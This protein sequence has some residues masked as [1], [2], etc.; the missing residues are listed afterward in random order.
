MLEII[1]KKHIADIAEIE[2]LCFSSPW[3]EK[4]LELLCRENNF[5]IAVT[6][7]EKAVAYGGM[8]C[9][10][11]E[12]EILNI[13]VHPDYRRRGYGRAVVRAL[14]AEAEKRGI[15]KIFLEVRASNLPAIALYSSEGFEEV[16]IR[17][18]FYSFP[19][20]DGIQMIY[21]KDKK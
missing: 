19:T 5:G 10:L 2:S 18:G 4:A 16:G 7:G 13:A 20:E 3:S 12:G 14:L 9:I 6:E 15:T 11:D 17:K 8:T 1:E 21:S